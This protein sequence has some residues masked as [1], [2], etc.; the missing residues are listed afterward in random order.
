MPIFNVPT[1]ENKCVSMKFGK[2]KRLSLVDEGMLVQ[3][4]YHLH[5]NEFFFLMSFLNLV[6]Q[7]LKR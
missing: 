3:V 7:F 2:V 6:N 4:R 5:I 1:D